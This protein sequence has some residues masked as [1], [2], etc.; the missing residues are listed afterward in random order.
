MR[1]EGFTLVELVVVVGIIGILL[2][3]A[4]MEY[5]KMQQKAAIEGQAR[6]VY[7]K[8]V[9]VRSD[10]MY[11]KTART[12]TISGNQMNIF[13]GSVTTVAPTSIIQLG[14]PMVTNPSSGEVDYN[15]QGLMQSA[16]IAIC[17]QPDSSG[18]NPGYIDS[19][20]VS[21][22]RTYM[23]KRK[24]GAA[25]ES[26]NIDQKSRRLHAGGTQGCH[27]HRGGRHVRRA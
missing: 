20:V 11:T 18:S 9:E 25:C 8:L 17:V 15:D 13:P 23:G 14:L 10:A 1:Q 4:L 19:V 26:G 21:T 12:V 3:I 2:T 6:T 5:G 22:V 24:T 7:S 27:D 16:D